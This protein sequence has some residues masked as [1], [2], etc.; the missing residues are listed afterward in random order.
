MTVLLSWGGGGRQLGCDALCKILADYKRYFR[1][2]PGSK[3]NNSSGYRGVK[4]P[5]FDW[6]G[7]SYFLDW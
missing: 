6:Y 2:P 3:S 7:N 1:V 5:A 4:F